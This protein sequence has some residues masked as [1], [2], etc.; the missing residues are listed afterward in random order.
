MVDVKPAASAAAIPS[1]DSKTGFYRQRIDS[2]HNLKAALRMSCPVF[3]PK[4]IPSARG[5]R[6]HPF[7]RFAAVDYLKLYTG[8]SKYRMKENILPKPIDL[9][10]VLWVILDLLT[11]VAGVSYITSSGSNSLGIILPLYPSIIIFTPGA[12]AGGVVINIES[13][14]AA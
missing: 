8:F 6:L 1:N 5:N 3:L 4:Q 10:A 9:Q 7:F 14:I 13:P 11:N 2:F 12:G